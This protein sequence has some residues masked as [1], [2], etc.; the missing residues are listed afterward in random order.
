MKM[1]IGFP[2]GVAVDA[3]FRGHHLVTDQPPKAGGNDTGPQP[4]DVF[5]ASIGTCAGFYALRFCQ[6]RAIDASELAIEL[7]TVR[8]AETRKLTRVNLHLTLP[9]EFPKKYEKAIIRAID[10]CAVKKAILDPPEIE[11]VIATPVPS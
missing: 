4:F 5:L 1:Q 8:D 3:R 2:G 10:Q 6:K 7:E 11:T 9:S